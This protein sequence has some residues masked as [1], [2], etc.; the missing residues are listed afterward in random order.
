MRP[1][2]ALGVVVTIIVALV[3]LPTVPR[4]EYAPANYAV[5]TGLALAVP[6]LLI[7]LSLRLLAKPN[8]WRWVLCAAAF[9]VSIPFVLFALF[10]S[11]ELATVAAK[12]V[13]PS[14]EPVGELQSEHAAYR[15]YRTN[16]GAMTSFGIVLRRERFLAPGLKLVRVVRNFYPASEATLERLPSGLFRL[17]VA[18]YGQRDTGQVFEFKPES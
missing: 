18:P 14:F 3:E 9:L 13:D 17:T 10:A 5:V 8:W 1:L 7:W 11:M 12:S 6:C 16:G 2:F 15:V 4:F